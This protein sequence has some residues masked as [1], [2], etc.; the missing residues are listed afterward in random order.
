MNWVVYPAIALKLKDKHQVVI[1]EVK[2]AF[3]NR[4]GRFAREMRPQ[5]QGGLPRYWFISE[6]DTGRRLKVVFVNDPDES[7]PVIITADEPNSKEEVL[8]ASITQGR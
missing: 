6:T 1:D 7:G 8:Y 5:N 3:L 4:S 2:Q